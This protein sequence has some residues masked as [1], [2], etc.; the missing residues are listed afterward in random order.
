MQLGVCPYPYVSPVSLK[1]RDCQQ[2]RS[3]VRVL[4]SALCV[5]QPC[6]NPSR[7]HKNTA[8]NGLAA[9]FANQPRKGYAALLHDRNRWFDPSIAHSQRTATATANVSIRDSTADALTNLAPALPRR[10]PHLVMISTFSPLPTASTDLP[11][12]P[13]LLGSSERLRPCLPDPCP[14]SPPPPA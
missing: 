2:R 9:R 6:S 11:F 8:E 3:R 4:P 5:Q 13:T 12:H 7:K 14:P 10:L 1:E